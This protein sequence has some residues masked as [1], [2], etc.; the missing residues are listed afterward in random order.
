MRT[1]QLYFIRIKRDETVRID[2][3]IDDD[4]KRAIEQ[5]SEISQGLPCQNTDATPE[6]VSIIRARRG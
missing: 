1:V 3:I 6:I 4:L 5:N 2:N